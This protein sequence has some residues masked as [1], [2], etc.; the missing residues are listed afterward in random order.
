MSGTSTPKEKAASIPSQAPPAQATPAGDGEGN[1]NM[2]EALRELVR[3]QQIPGYDA[4][5]IQRVLDEDAR[6]AMAGLGPEGY[7]DL[8]ND[9]EFTV[10]GKKKGARAA[11]KKKAPSTFFTL[12]SD[13][14]FDCGCAVHTNLD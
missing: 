8:D 12:T 1:F 6:E 7:I 2:Q 10:V 13:H 5:A 11:V 4:E 9:N 14:A 3:A